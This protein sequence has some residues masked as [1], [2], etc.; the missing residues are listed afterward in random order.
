MSMSSIRHGV[1]EVKGHGRYT[2]TQFYSND[3]GK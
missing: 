2:L 1:T 3:W